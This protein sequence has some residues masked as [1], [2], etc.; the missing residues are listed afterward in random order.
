MS[1]CPDVPWLV[2]FKFMRST[3][4]WRAALS[5]AKVAKWRRWRREACISAR[6]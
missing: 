6:M 3:H 2:A 4:L 5:A 1:L